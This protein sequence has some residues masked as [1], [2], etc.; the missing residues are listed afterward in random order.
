M[1]GPIREQALP[2]LASANNHG[3][4]AVKL[5]SLKQLKDVLLSAEP[6]QVAELLSYLIDLQSSPESLLRKCLIQ[7][8]E[9]VGMKAKEHLLALM[10]V[11]FACLKDMNSMVAKQSIISGMKIFC[12]VL[13]ELSSQ[14]HRHGIVERWLEELWTW[15]VKFKDAVFGVIFEAVPIGTKLLVLKFLETY[16]LLFTSSDSEKSGAQAKHGW[17]FNISWV[18]GHHPV[19]DPASLASDAK[20]NVGT[21]L[22]LLHSASSLPGLLTISV[23]NS[24][25]PAF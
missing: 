16:I 17:T 25:S 9:A 18:V 12:G 2:L 5:S 10:P 1:A 20:N 22:D 3:D 11:L 19:L 7:V 8:I 21:L 13:E 24:M 4:L 23:I 15:M 6:S 14:F